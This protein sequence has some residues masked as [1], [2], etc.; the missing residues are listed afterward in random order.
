M[1]RIGDTCCSFPGPSGRQYGLAG[2]L[3]KDCLLLFGEESSKDT[4]PLPLLSEQQLQL[5]YFFFLLET[6]RV[7]FSFSTKSTCSVLRCST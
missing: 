3:V 1:E 4:L 5:V 2:G 7:G 6:T